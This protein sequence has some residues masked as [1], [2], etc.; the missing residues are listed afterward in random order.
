[1]VS[2]E[3]YDDINTKTLFIHCLLR[4]NHAHK[5]WRGID[6]PPGS[7]ITGRKALSTETKLTEQQ[8]RTCLN[9]L[10]STNDITIKTTSKYSLVT[11]VNW[12]F[13]QGREL[14][15]PSD[16]PCKPP[17]I[18]QQST[19]NQPQTTIKQLNNK[20][21]GSRSRAFVPPTVNEVREYLFEKGV[22]S[23]TAES[24]VNHY[25]ATGW[26]RGKNKIKNWKLCVGT[27]ISREGGKPSQPYGAGGI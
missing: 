16:Q 6:V 26:M 7:F 2:W 23:F 12:D 27:W 5:K 11:V 24:F 1:M 17:A 10:K 13:Y 22:T 21:K 4:A 20:E 3:W 15:Q 9:R 25:G 14:N 18:N 8:V 19:S